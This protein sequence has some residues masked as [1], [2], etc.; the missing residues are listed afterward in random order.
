MSERQPIPRH[1]AIIMDGNGRWAKLRGKERYE[2][3][4]QG[5]AAVREAVR[6]AVRNGVEYLTLYAFSTENW[7][8]P[9]EEVE[10]LMSLFCTSVINET[11]SLVEQGVRVK[12]IGHRSHFSEKVQRY[13]TE[14]EERTA[15]GGRLT[16]ILAIDYSSR[17]EITDAVRK[18]AA[19]VAD[20]RIG[21]AEITERTIGQAL[22]TADYPDPD[23]IIRTSGECRLSNFLLWQASYAE[24]YFPQVLWPDFT[25]E[26]FDKAMEVYA[27]RERRYGLI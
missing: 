23:F 5:V 3:H 1:V 21:A 18:I 19:E 11:P 13:L 24:F 7:G 27:S 20:G 15:D 17:D 2:G 12:L 10:A 14:I 9:A 8:R 6:A 16:L 26:D 22:Y 25:E 4:I